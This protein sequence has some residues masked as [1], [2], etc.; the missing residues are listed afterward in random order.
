M[1]ELAPSFYMPG[2]CL[3]NARQPQTLRQN[4]A[5]AELRRADADPRAVADFIDRVADI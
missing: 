2:C 5:D 4:P 1:A 3:Y